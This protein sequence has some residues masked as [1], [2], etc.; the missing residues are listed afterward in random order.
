MHLSFFMGLS[1][2]KSQVFMSHSDQFCYVMF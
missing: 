1:I 2:R